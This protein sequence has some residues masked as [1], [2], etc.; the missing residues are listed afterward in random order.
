MLARGPGRGGDYCS[1]RRISPSGEV[2][3]ERVRAGAGHTAPNNPTLWVDSKGTSRV[4]LGDR[5]HHQRPDDHR[6]TAEAANTR[7]L[8]ARP[9]EP[10]LRPGERTYTK[11]EGTR[12]GGSDGQ[13]R[14][15]TARTQDQVESRYEPTEGIP[16]GNRSRRA[17]RPL[18]E[19]CPWAGLRPVADRPGGPPVHNCGQVARL[20][21]VG[22][23]QTT[24]SHI[25]PLPRQSL[26]IPPPPSTGPRL[27][28][29]RASP[30]RS[31]SRRSGPTP[32]CA[33]HRAGRTCHLPPPGAPG[34]PPH[35]P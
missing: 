18:E 30:C 7:P 2:L 33:P 3:A 11:R 22:A 28:T 13:R 16:P 35:P 27:R 9:Q 34:A 15:L 10:R 21:E 1:I 23:V 17:S 24:N 20:R 26:T 32:G 25:E 6:H 19:E 5:Q 12:P 31:R 29:W 14:D 8:A 4:R